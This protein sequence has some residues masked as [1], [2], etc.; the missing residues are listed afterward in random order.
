MLYYGFVYVLYI[1]K[2]ALFP[3]A[4]SNISGSMLKQEL[5]M[6]HD[7]SSQIESLLDDMSNCTSAE[8]FYGLQHALKNA[9]KEDKDNRESIEQLIQSKMEGLGVKKLTNHELAMLWPF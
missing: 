9:S 6:N 7:L 3:Q 1:K 8:I 2:G 4:H 5:H